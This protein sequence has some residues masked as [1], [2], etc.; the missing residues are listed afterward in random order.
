MVCPFSGFSGSVGCNVQLG[1]NYA[2]ASGDNNTRNSGMM[3][4]VGAVHKPRRLFRRRGESG[5]SL[6]NLYR[7]SRK[8]YAENLRGGIRSE[9]FKNGST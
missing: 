9:I 5:R 7:F 8:L 4:Y 1:E 3:Y 2:A 6:R